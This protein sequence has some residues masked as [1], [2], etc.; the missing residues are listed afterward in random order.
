M[1]ECKSC[2]SKNQ[3][4]VVAS[5]ND[6]DDINHVFDPTPAYNGGTVGGRCCSDYTTTKNS[7]IT[8]GQ[9]SGLYR[10]DGPLNIACCQC[11][12]SMI[13]GVDVNQKCTL[14]V[15]IKYSDS[16]MNVSLELEAGKIYTFQYVEDGVLKQVTGKLT[17]IYKTYDCNN[18]TLFKLAVD[19]SVD[20]T[21]SRTVIKSDQLR[22]VSEY[23]KYADQNPTI[24]NSIHR[25]GTTTAEVIKDAVVV[26]AIIDKNGNLIEGTIIDGKINGYTVDGLAQGKNDRMVPITV[27]NGQTMN[28]TITEGQILNGILR[29]GSVDGEKDP[30]TEIVSKATVTGTISN[31]I[32]INTIVSGGKT[33]NGTII[34]PVINNSILTNGVITGE[35]MV[36]TGGITV[37]DITTGGTTKG[38]IGEGGVATG[39]INGKQFTI[40][41]GKTTGNL[42]STGGTL[43][44]GTIIGGTKVG[45]TIVNA[46]IKGGVYSN[47]VTTGGNTSEG[48]I[49]ASKAD[50]T[51]IAK[52]AGRTN[53]SMPK[54]IKQFDVP[55]DGYE[56]QCDCCHDNEEVMYKNGLILF[57]DRRFNNFGTNMSADW[58]E[59][60]GICNDNCN[61]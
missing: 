29:S 48:V 18:N 54:V 22:G 25:Y 60:A 15:T 37:G 8:P 49:T 50:T 46:V 57:A 21:T 47:G 12:P 45:R 28:G 61:N 51:P 32:A 36:T 33:S 34:N 31:V 9:M 16:S 17:D 39:C 55:V 27:I 59:R 24:D 30:K 52:N 56:N 20:Y 2:N 40:E 53:T 58:E 44:G 3:Y 6:C 19:S 11:T 42:V 4:T 14:V 1:P 13:L 41:G 5:N 7:N 10:A 43:V 35:D 23:S 26:N 38:G